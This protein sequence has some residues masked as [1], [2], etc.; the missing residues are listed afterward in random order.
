MLGLEG[1]A[2]VANLEFTRSDDGEEIDAGARWTGTWGPLEFQFGLSL[3]HYERDG[4]HIEID[5]VSVEASCGSELGSLQLRALGLDASVRGTWEIRATLVPNVAAIGSALGGDLAGAATGALEGEAAAEAGTTAGAIE[6]EETGAAAVQAGSILPAIV[7]LAG[8][9]ITV[10]AVAA[11][12]SRGDDFNRA[13]VSM[14]REIV[15]YCCAFAHVLR[16]EGPGHGAGA[17]AGASAAR[18]VLAQLARRGITPEQIAA[19]TRFEALYRLA[20]DRIA[21]ALERRLADIGGGAVR[22]ADAHD[23]I[24]SSAYNG[25]AYRRYAR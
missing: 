7:G 20:W 13:T 24:G 8:V 15:H 12:L 23:L 2:L 3:L 16:G 4:S 14:Q 6:A 1:H 21:P 11:T 10:A 22:A 18:D 17:G 9:A 25:G 19:S 5:P